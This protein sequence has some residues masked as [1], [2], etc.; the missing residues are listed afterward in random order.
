MHR[1]ACG[2]ALLIAGC[3][4]STDERPLTVE[5]VTYA[6]LSPTCG[7]APCH[8]SFRQAR[9]DVFDT[10]AGVR[11]S[12][13]DNGLI[14]FDSPV[15]DPAKP[16]N[17]QLI[18]WLTKT[19]PLG[20]GIGRMPYDAPMP[21]EDIKFLEDWIGAGAPG[22]QCDPDA[23]NGFACNDKDQV[24]CGPDWVFG[25]VTQSCPNECV[26]GGCR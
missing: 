20:L 25:E 21:N 23:N 6:I 24:R 4:V 7:A 12:L 10:I 22:A 15:Y 11:Y 18:Q 14:K 19:D 1:L 2:L 3:G 17:S 16:G 5:Y 9:G 26:N 13:V 8:S